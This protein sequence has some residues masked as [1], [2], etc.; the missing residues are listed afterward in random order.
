MT[1]SLWYWTGQKIV[2]NFKSTCTTIHLEKSTH[3]RFSFSLGLWIAVIALWTVDSSSKFWLI[4][5]IFLLIYTYN[6]LIKTQ[7][8]TL[9]LYSLKLTNFLMNWN[10]RNLFLYILIIIF[11][12]RSFSFSNETPLS[13]FKLKLVHF[14]SLPKKCQLNHPNQRFGPHQFLARLA[15]SMPIR[16]FI[17]KKFR[18]LDLIMAFQIR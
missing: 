10:Q 12:F 16:W 14:W 9:D 3:L 17:L 6:L 1:T 18:P 8:H 2:E 4:L 15:L 5:H 7:Q 11:L 13:I